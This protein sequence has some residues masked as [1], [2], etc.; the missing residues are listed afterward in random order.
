MAMLLQSIGTS[1]ASDGQPHAVQI[2]LDVSE[3]GR[4]GAG[5]AGFA[6]LDEFTMQNVSAAGH[7]Q[8][9]AK[10]QIMREH[11]ISY[12]DRQAFGGIRDLFEPLSDIPVT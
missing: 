4:R 1:L 6:R 9:Y 10:L 5:R 7:P 11:S 8:T 3:Q 2:A 12:D